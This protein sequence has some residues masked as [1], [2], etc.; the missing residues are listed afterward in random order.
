MLLVLVAELHVA[1]LEAGVLVVVLLLQVRVKGGTAGVL[2]LLLE[3]GGCMA[4]EH[5]VLRGGR[6]VRDEQEVKAQQARRHATITPRR[7][8]HAATRVPPPLPRRTPQTPC[9]HQPL[10]LVL[11]LAALLVV[12]GQ[13]AVELGLG[14]GVVVALQLRAGGRGRWVGR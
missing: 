2:V 7:A 11:V 13:R 12:A 9:A 1:L 5:L 3:G 14:L 4:V 6:G 10:L 8:S